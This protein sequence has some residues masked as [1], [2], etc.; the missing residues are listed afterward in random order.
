MLVRR[1]RVIA[2]LSLCFGA[3]AFSGAVSVVAP[4]AAQMPLAK[5]LPV[6]PLTI[7]TSD[8]K[9]HNFK[10]EVASKPEERSQ[11]LMYRRS[12]APDA[13]MLFDFGHT[14]PVAMWM[15]N[16]LIPLDMLF[17]AADGT[18]VNIAQRTVPQSLATIPS[19][20]PVRFVL[21]VPGGTAS[22]LKIQPGDKLIYS[23]IGGQGK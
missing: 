23:A 7:A 15:A 17:V 11:G 4:V 2:L 5:P 3:L 14:A 1:S 16:T 20:G 9:K 12:L 19:D 18:I 22:R 6:S 8:G 13:G 21:E 10:V